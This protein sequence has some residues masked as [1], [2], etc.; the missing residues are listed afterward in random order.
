MNKISPNFDKTMFGFFMSEVWF[1]AKVSVALDII[2]FNRLPVGRTDSAE[3]TNKE[4]GFSFACGKAEAVSGTGWKFPSAL[5]TEHAVRMSTHRHSFT[6]ERKPLAVE[7]VKGTEKIGTWRVPLPSIL[8]P[9][10]HGQDLLFM[11][12]G[13]RN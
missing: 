8:L 12:K 10:S 13:Y 5:T 1:P 4:D 9:K 3:R 2:N 11:P 7:S 6:A